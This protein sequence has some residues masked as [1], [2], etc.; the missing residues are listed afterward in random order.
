MEFLKKVN[1]LVLG[2]A[3]LLTFGCGKEEEPEWKHVHEPGSHI[4]GTDLQR[5]KEVTESTAQTGRQYKEYHNGTVHGNQSQVE[6]RVQ[7]A[8]FNPLA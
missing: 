6:F 1:A 4:A 2:L 8:A 3:V 5:N 7:L